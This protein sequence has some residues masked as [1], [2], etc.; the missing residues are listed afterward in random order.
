MLLVF[1]PIYRLRF[2][3]MTRKKKSTLNTFSNVVVVVDMCVRTTRPSKIKMNRIKKKHFFFSSVCPPKIRNACLI[4]FPITVYV[5]VF[6]WNSQIQKNRQ[7]IRQNLDEQYK[8]KKTNQ[9][10]FH[11][12]FCSFFLWNQKFHK[13]I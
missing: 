3:E 12:F 6:I 5:S 13:S 8:K 1:V 7:F 4:T 10:R 2:A 11:F 9:R